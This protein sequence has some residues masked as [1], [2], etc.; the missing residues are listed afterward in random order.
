M[1]YLVTELDL[2][3]LA[4]DI[5]P[6]IITDMVNL[7][8]ELLFNLKYPN[9]N[10]DKLFYSCTLIYDFNAVGVIKFKFLTFRIKLWNHFHEKFINND[11]SIVLRASIY[12]PKFF[13]PSLTTIK[14]KVN[15]PP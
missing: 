7:N 12:D 6:P 10:P 5:P 3:Q 15:I 13:M 11:D 1:S 9:A 14:V 4:V 2:P 8:Q